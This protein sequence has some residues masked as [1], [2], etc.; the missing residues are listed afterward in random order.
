MARTKGSVIVTKNIE[1]K[2]YLQKVGQ[3]IY[4]YNS[5]T[6][7]IPEWLDDLLAG[8][9][10]L[11]TGTR[12]PSSYRVFRMI[13]VLDEISTITVAEYLNVKRIA[14]GEKLYSTTTIKNWM[15]SLVCANKAITH[16]LRGDFTYNDTVVD[17]KGLKASQVFKEATILYNGEVILAK[18]LHKQL[19]HCYK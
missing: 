18:D 13:S 11:Q 16:H 12:P 5:F 10:N 15:N 2:E 9:G 7:F 8:S 4:D 3:D 6:N 17:E 19:Q 14:T 1:V